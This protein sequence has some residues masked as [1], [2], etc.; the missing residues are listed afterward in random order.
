MISENYRH[1]V[2]QGRD[3]DPLREE[4]TLDLEMIP[5]LSYHTDLHHGS[6]LPPRGICGVAT[7]SS[8]QRNEQLTPRP[9]PC[10]SR[11]W[12]KWARIRAGAK[13]PALRVM[14]DEMTVAVQSSM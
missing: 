2:V 8:V 13:V 6:I 3:R 7:G 5:L 14:Y 1:Q 9:L 10:G 11:P 4:S 12:K